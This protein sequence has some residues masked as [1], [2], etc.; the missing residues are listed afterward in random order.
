MCSHQM[1]YIKRESQQSEQSAPVS[2]TE[3]RKITDMLVADALG[4][5][6][7]NPPAR[8]VPASAAISALTPKS[9]VQA[10]VLSS[11]CSHQ[12]V[13]IKRESQQSEQSAPVSIAE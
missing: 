1:V 3:V 7:S 11:M 6:V 10:P 4:A 9:D 2:I 5:V 13:Y 12:M 8:S